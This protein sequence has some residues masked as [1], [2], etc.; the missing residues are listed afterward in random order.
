MMH[1][2]S[3]AAASSWQGGCPIIAEIGNGS[4]QCRASM[5]YGPIQDTR[6]RPTKGT[7]MSQRVL[8]VQGP[9]HLSFVIA[10]PW[11]V[12]T[13]QAM[14]EVAHSQST[15]LSILITML[16]WR[17]FV[18]FRSIARSFNLRPH[19]VVYGPMGFSIR[20]WMS[21]RKSRLGLQGW[22]MSSSDWGESSLHGSSN[23]RLKEVHQHLNRP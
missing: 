14:E 8:A 16:P 10:I 13:F 2:P 6:S 3:R 4:L 22:Q 19:V 9:L 17:I 15:T 20:S 18:N 12:L 7:W 5:W 11:T 23:C 21:K 1:G